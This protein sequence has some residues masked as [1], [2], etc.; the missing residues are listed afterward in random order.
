MSFA[1]S[2]LDGIIAW[3]RSEDIPSGGADP[4]NW[5]DVVS[6]WRLSASG[7]ARAAYSA[8]AIGGLPGLN[9]DGTSD[10][11]T[12]TTTK[13][14]TNNTQVAIVCNLTSQSTARGLVS[15]TPSA[16]PNYTTALMAVDPYGAQWYQY[17]DG[18]YE[19]YK[20]VQTAG[21]NT[22]VRCANGICNAGI[23]L[24]AERCRVAAGDAT[25]VAQLITKTCY[26]HLGAGS[27]SGQRFLGPISEVVMW[28]EPAVGNHYLWIEGY[29][30]HK[31]GITL[32]TWHTFYA[33]A[34]TSPPLTG[35]TSR[36]QHPMYQ[37]VIG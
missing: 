27:S 3:W 37:Q 17:Y 29:L 35:G 30:A 5:D 31:F 13:S 26:V 2:D 20:P 23:F 6:G 18:K 28:E 1:P 15:V 21:A 24:S 25:T 32:P 16:T 33:S 19:S 8:T 14:L 10:F 9:F 36:P 12:T 4:L 22:V 7:T 34:P 11:M